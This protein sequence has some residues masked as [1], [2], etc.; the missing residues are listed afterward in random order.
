MIL[1]AS[2]AEE[3]RLQI[4]MRLA[5]RDQIQRTYKSMYTEMGPKKKETFSPRLKFSLHLIK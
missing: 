1:S 2:I 3:I 5:E 4:W